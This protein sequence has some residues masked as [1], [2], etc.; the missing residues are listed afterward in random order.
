MR[1]HDPWMCAATLRTSE[2]NETELSISAINLS[3]DTGKDLETWITAPPDEQFYVLSH[4]IMSDALYS[5][6]LFDH[7]DGAVYAVQ[8]CDLTFV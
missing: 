6:I 4:D 2:G 7:R 8:S 5:Y 3:Q 1:G